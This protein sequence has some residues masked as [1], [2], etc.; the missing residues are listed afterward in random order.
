[1]SEDSD[2]KTDIRE[3]VIEWIKQNVAPAVDSTNAM[4]ER[5]TERIYIGSRD[6][7][8]TTLIGVIIGMMTNVSANFLLNGNQNLGIIFLLL[9]LMV[10][11]LS[12][13][14]WR[15]YLKIDLQHFT[16]K[17]VYV[18]GKF[19]SEKFERDFADLKKDQDKE[20][21]HTFQR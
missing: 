20:K 7:L 19:L 21:E 4:I 17:H 9:S 10:A 8:A 14:L 13:H 16:K 6:I 18:Q 5:E 1:M 12:F 11:V 2:E 15:L 3:K